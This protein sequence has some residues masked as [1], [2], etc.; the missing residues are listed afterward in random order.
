M[1]S[2]GE[3][4]YAS[5]SRGS[6][7]FDV[8]GNI[9]VE[10]KDYFLV[11]KYE[12][13]E[14]DGSGFVTKV[15]P[16]GGS[17]GGGGSST[18]VVN[19]LLS[20]SPTSA[21]SANKGRE[22]RETIGST[23]GD[24]HL[25][26]FTG[27][28]ITDN[29]SVKV[30]LQE[31]ETAIE[32]AGTSTPLV[33]TGATGTGYTFDGTIYD[34]VFF[35][36]GNSGT[37]QIP[38]NPVEGQTYHIY[39]EKT[40]GGNSAV[41]LDPAYV[42]HNNDPISTLSLLQGSGNRLLLTATYNGSQMVSRVLD[43]DSIQK[44]EYI[45]LANN[46]AALQAITD[47]Q[48][49][50]LYQIA[51]DETIFQVRST[52]DGTYAN[53]VLVAINEQEYLQ[54]A[55]FENQYA[56]TSTANG[57]RSVAIS[58]GF[59]DFE[60]S[61]NQ[62][63]NS[64]TDSVLDAEIVAEGSGDGSWLSAQ[65]GTQNG[66]N[67]DFDEVLVYHF[68]KVKKIK[69]L[70]ISPYAATSFANRSAKDIEISSGNDEVALQTTQGSNVLD[71]VVPAP[72]GDSDNTASVQVIEYEAEAKAIRI[73]IKSNYATD[74]S[75]ANY[76]FVGLGK[77]FA[78]TEDKEILELPSYLP[79]GFGEVVADPVFKYHVT[80]GNVGSNA[81]FEVAPDV[82]F[83]NTVKA[84]ISSLT[85]N[86]TS[87]ETILLKGE[88]LADNMVIVPSYT[89][90][91]LDGTVTTSSLRASGGTNWAHNTGV[92]EIG[93]TRQYYRIV[94]KSRTSNVATVE[95]Y[96]AH[97]Y[98]VNNFVRIESMTDSG[99]DE[100]NV[101]ITSVPTPTTFTYANTG[102]D[103]ASSAEDGGRATNNAITFTPIY[104]AH[105]TMRK[106][107]KVQGDLFGDVAEF[108]PQNQFAGQFV[109]PSIAFQEDVCA[110]HT[111][112]TLI[113][114][115][116]TDC[117]AENMHGNVRLENL[118]RDSV[119]Q[120]FQNVIKGMRGR[121]LVVGSEF[122][123]NGYNASK[124]I[125]T[126]SHFE[127]C[128]DDMVAIVASSG[129][130]PDSDALHVDV[131]VDG[132]TGSKNG[133]RGA[134]V[135]IDGGEKVI[136]GLPNGRGSC[137]RIVVNNVNVSTTQNNTNTNG[138]LEDE[139][140]L[141]IAEGGDSRDITYNNITGNG[142]FRWGLY[143]N[144]GCQNLI[145][146]NFNWTA[147]RG[148]FIVCPNEPSDNQ[149]VHISNGIGVA[150]QYPIIEDLSF[151]F[152]CLG[153]SSAQG[154]RNLTMSNV[155]LQGFEHPIAEG[156]DSPLITPAEQASLAGLGVTGTYENF[157]YHNVDI[158][159]RDRTDCIFSS[160]NRIERLKKHGLL[161]YDS[162]APGIVPPTDVNATGSF[163]PVNGDTFVV[164]TSTTAITT[165]FDITAL[166]PG[167]TFTVVDGEEN[168]A[169]NNITLETSG[170]ET[171][172]GFANY[173]I[174]NNGSAIVLIKR[175]DGNLSIL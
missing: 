34:T 2:V 89:E 84:A 14:V 141:Y 96:A 129:G 98:E 137:R 131:L 108:Y 79:D 19:N 147:L 37:L 162:Q 78:V 54:L 112:N 82:D 115:S 87:V 140:V 145:L 136:T 171:I 121:Y 152:L 165:T 76:W 72:D 173:T 100:V 174:S 81:D 66:L 134:A 158:Q 160:I 133:L 36:D 94:S 153:G 106:G 7:L 109:E 26:T 164:D 64:P 132:V 90:I 48:E 104:D 126:D 155:K 45:I 148:I 157:E 58:A 75:N 21:L 86:R 77:V 27:M 101:Q 18:V 105:I 8:S 135:K 67:V 85:E 43:K 57:E 68:N 159:G 156:Y 1:A 163:T 71:Y 144:F 118:G 130:V 113:R 60:I 62:F 123:A 97:G 125:V 99:Y 91:I 33:V 52:T 74:S 53:T 92:F 51:G 24:G 83:S 167:S 12:V 93:P 103:D 73:N 80:V 42:D 47:F 142:N 31:L 128:V 15:K 50:R 55:L 11:G 44:E 107:S 169:T 28:T 170:A 172:N 46:L 175:N 88:F 149:H 95:T 23:D 5:K 65:T 40:I 127:N 111:R 13:T 61:G 3:I 35:K 32:S 70:L 168:A 4:I 17:G 16:L 117:R 139:A 10:S 119:I 102:A 120:S 63:P 29:T 30:A 39:F 38:S 49:G 138:A 143:A 41:A 114:C 124:T 150:R 110:V 154:I 59:G 22:L 20:T 9:V 151:G 6:Q 116:F 56:S 69:Y 146:N 122:Y 161:I 25:G 166:L